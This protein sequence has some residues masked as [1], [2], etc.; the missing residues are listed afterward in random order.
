MDSTQP[1]LRVAIVGGGIGGLTLAV[2]LHKLC[3]S[4]FQVDIYEAA[5]TLTEI[6][7]GIGVWPRVWEVM[8]ALDL[9]SDLSKISN[10]AGKEGQP[11][12]FRK[13]DYTVKGGSTSEGP[14][15]SSVKLAGIRPFHRA[16]FQAILA[17]HLPSNPSYTT[18]FRKRLASYEAS[19]ID[20]T[21]IDLTFTDGSQVVCDLLIGCDGIKSVVRA[22]L[23]RPLAHPADPAWSGSVAYRSLIPRDVLEKIDP[24]HPSLTKA[25]VACGHNKH[26]IAFPI[27]QATLINIV[28]F[29]SQPEQEGTKYDGAWVREASKQELLDAY[30]GWEPTMI[31]LL[32]CAEKVTLW[33]INTIP[34]LP[35]YVGERVA[36]I[37]DAAHA[38]TPH[39][40]SGAGQAIE[41]GFVLASLLADPR[42]NRQT[43]PRVLQIYDAIRRPFSQDIMQRSRN[44]GRLY[45]FGLSPTESEGD[46]VGMTGHS[47]ADDIARRSAA[48]QRMLSWAVETSVM[49]DR[50]RALQA[51][52]RVTEELA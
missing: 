23:Y 30:A 8:E 41:D 11:A 21:A 36:L 40:G 1:K 16:Q 29:V 26:I 7:A 50:D 22:T 18:H 35:T 14:A 5:H 4:R 19:S 12:E 20:Q 6:G 15:S 42:T 28:C 34:P 37:G 46:V 27:A 39:Q 10:D 32:N 49:D 31:E 24:E 3:G 2:A 9:A 17:A 52:D 25:V 48:L 13:S 44:S 33:A 45:E 51:L 43:L 38:M 47:A